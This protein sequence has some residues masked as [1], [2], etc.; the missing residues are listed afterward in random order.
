MDC[1]VHQLGTFLEGISSYLPPEMVQIFTCSALS[2]YVHEVP[3]SQDWYVGALEYCRQTIIPSAYFLHRTHVE[4][5]YSGTEPGIAVI[6][7]ERC[8]SA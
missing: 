6:E 8:L 4:T 7:N 3:T 2:R 1:R 5:Q